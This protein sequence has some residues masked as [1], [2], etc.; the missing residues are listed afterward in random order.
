VLHVEGDDGGTETIR[1]CPGTSPTSLIIILAPP[2]LGTVV[3][4]ISALLC[5]VLLSSTFTVSTPDQYR[6]TIIAMQ[7]HR[8][9][10]PLIF[11]YNLNFLA[12]E[13]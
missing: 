1:R 2:P 7:V 4:M 13:E 3:T 9:Q 8:T 12:R 11:L 10:T 6:T 5:S